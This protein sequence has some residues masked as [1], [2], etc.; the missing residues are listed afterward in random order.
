MEFDKT[1]LEKL[2]IE[3]K[4]RGFSQKTIDAYKLHNKLFLDHI[5]KPAEKI[6]EDDVKSYIAHLLTKDQKPASINIAISSLKFYYHNVIKNP[7]LTEIRGVKKERKE[8]IVLTEKEIRRL[9]DAVKNSKHLLLL[10]FMYSSGLRVS[11]CVKLERDDVNIEEGLL[12]IRQAKGKKDRVV[13]LAKS[14]IEPLQQYLSSRKDDSKYLFPSNKGGHVSIK[15]AQI[16][17]KDAAKKANIKKRV[18]CHMLRASYATHLH[19][20]GIDS[21]TIQV[22]LGHSD[23][24]TT[25]HYT[26]VSLKQIKE[27]ESPLDDL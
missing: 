7:I 27:V 15:L 14:I 26:R 16:L 11:E 5:K 17:I 3:L 21:R 23:L 25:Q 4:I 9:F 8:P 12:N 18:F 20:R 19:Q 13:K 22:L 1:M 24:S 2:E 6:N 10:K